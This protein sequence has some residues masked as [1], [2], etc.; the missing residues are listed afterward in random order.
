MNKTPELILWT[1]FN[2][3]AISK[4]LDP[5]VKKNTHNRTKTPFLAFTQRGPKG[6]V[7]LRTKAGGVDEIKVGDYIIKRSD[8]D[9]R[10]CTKETAAQFINAC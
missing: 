9:Y 10:L 3:D 2:W 7:L 6:V 1:G 4:F 8:E 5:L